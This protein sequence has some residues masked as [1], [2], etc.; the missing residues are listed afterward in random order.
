MTEPQGYLTALE[1]TPIDSKTWALL[2]DFS[3][4]GSEG[5]VFTVLAGEETDF[6]TVP[7]W[8]Q[9]I[10]PRT[11]TWTKAAVLHDKMCRERARHHRE[12]E[13]WHKAIDEWLVNPDPLAQIP[14]EPVEPAFSAVDADFVFRKNARADGT[15]PIRSE[16]LWLGVRWGA[17]ANPAR[18]GGWWSTFP[19]LALD[20]ILLLLVLLAIGGVIGWLYPW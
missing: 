10:L 9:A 6:A 8:T 5:D 20:T 19:R 2:E 17:A 18:H 16:L 14:R 7:W 3:W 4:R 15:D 12:L 1:V 13:L 11:G